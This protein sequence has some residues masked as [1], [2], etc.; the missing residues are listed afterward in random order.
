MNLIASVGVKY[1]FSL[2]HYSNKCHSAIWLAASHSEV[3]PRICASDTRPLLL[4]WTGWD[5]GTRLFSQCL[6][7]SIGKL[8]N[9]YPNCTTLP[10][11][12]ILAVVVLWLPP[13]TPSHMPS[14]L[15]K[16]TCCAAIR[17]AQIIRSNLPIILILYSHFSSLLFRWAYPII[18]MIITCHS[19]RRKFL[20]VLFDAK[21]HS[22]FTRAFS[23]SSYLSFGWRIT[24]QLTFM[25]KNRSFWRL[26]RL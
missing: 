3:S 23:A 25:R 14:R 12:F 9:A 17:P 15:Y 20:L 21:P 4:A 6:T 2:L 11:I 22:L 18:Q 13:P 8:V 7:A 19:T 16:N 5:L 1:L 26:Q 10:S 24:I